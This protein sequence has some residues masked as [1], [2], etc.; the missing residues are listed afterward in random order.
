MSKV[1]F[2]VHQLVSKY[3]TD[4]S[5]Q[6]GE[7][8]RKTILA[9]LYDIGITKYWKLVKEQAETLIEQLDHEVFTPVEDNAGPG[10]PVITVKVGSLAKEIHVETAD[11]YEIFHK[12]FTDIK[13]LAEDELK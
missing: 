4:H 6:I 7:E 1:L 5:D 10:R 3:Y 2:E 11:M 12:C 9:F 8:D 13:T